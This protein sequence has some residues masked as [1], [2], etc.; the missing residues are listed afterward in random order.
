MTVQLYIDHGATVVRLGIIARKNK[1][2]VPLQKKAAGEKLPAE[3]ESQP[4]VFNNSTLIMSPLHF[5][6]L[7]TARGPDVVVPSLHSSQ[8]GSKLSNQQK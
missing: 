5:F 4:C 1:T 8:S 7:V 6:V 2:P 3:A